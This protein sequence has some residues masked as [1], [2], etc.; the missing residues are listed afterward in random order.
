M[1]DQIWLESS[2][3]P[4]K[5]AGAEIE[6]E[7]QTT[8][9]SGKPVLKT[10]SMFLPLIVRNSAIGV[11]CFL[12]TSG[13]PFTQKDLDLG[14]DLASQL[15]GALKNLLLFEEN[16]KMERLATV[17]QT[18]SMVMHEIKNIIQVAKLAD[19]LIRRGVR[20][21]NEKFLS[22]G[23]EG[24]AK[25]IHE[26]DG[27]VWDMLSLT[28]DY[29]IETQK[30]RIQS[31]LEELFNDLHEKAEQIQIK[32]DFQTEE[33][34]PEVDADG[35]SLYRVFLNLVQNSMQACEK[36]E[37]YI[38]IRVRS[39]NESHYEV[40]IEDNGRGMTPEVRAKIFQAFFSTKGRQG[41]GLGL[42]IVDRTLKAHRGEIQLDSEAG[43][44]TT[45]TITLPK[46]IPNEES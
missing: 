46:L 7:A 29:K 4:S 28:K 11:A 14:F 45:F 10:T 37:S 24:T 5:E 16:L 31:L 32:L 25:A 40:V 6:A 42:M 26:M 23:L 27:F 38:R 18:V 44:G 2:T 35:R 39:K 15:A 41:T 30:V 21:K 43:K 3:G 33:P 17:G 1:N 12:K 13:T 8:L 34:F 36:D 9:Q 19:E 22:H 20:D